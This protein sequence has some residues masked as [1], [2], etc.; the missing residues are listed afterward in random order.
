MH[1]NR[2]QSITIDRRITRELLLSMAK[3]QVAI[4]RPPQNDSVVH[5]VTRRKDMDMLK[6]LIELGAN[7]NDVNV[8]GPACAALVRRKHRG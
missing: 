7:I 2:S 5:V 4:K 1:Y 6:N 8:G 3:E